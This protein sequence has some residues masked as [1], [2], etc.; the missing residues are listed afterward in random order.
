M[1][2]REKNAAILKAMDAQYRPLYQAYVL[3]ADLTNKE[4]VKRG[5]DLFLSFKN[6]NQSGIE[7]KNDPTGIDTECL[8][9]LI[10]IGEGALDPTEYKNL[11][12]FTELNM[13]ELIK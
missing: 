13:N 1:K 11:S 7:F 3:F 12:P 10:H 8:Q 5:I 9:I 6:M 4:F 2:T